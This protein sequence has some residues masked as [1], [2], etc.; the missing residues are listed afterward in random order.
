MDPKDEESFPRKSCMYGW[1]LICKWIPKMRKA[2]RGSLVCTVG[3]LICKW[4]AKDEKNFSRKS[5]KMR[6]TSQGS[7]VCTVGILICK[8]IA[9]DEKNFSR[10][11]CMYSWD[12]DL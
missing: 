10:K 2:S 4:I 1:D 9:K 12:F 8:W 7:P 5:C 6:K 3:I 11:S